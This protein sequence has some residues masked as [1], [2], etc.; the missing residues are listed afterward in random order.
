MSLRDSSLKDLTKAINSFIVDPKLPLPES[1][2]STID[3][4]L[5]KHD[6]SDDS[7]SDR[8]QNEL[9]TIFDKHVPDHPN[10]TGPWMGILRRLQPALQSPEKVLFWFDACLQLLDDG[11]P[12]E[13]LVVDEM[14][15]AM[16]NTVQIANL[17]Q[18][19]DDSEGNPIIDRLFSVWLNK[20]YP[21]VAN[22]KTSA[23]NNELLLRDT[24]MKFGKS[25]LKVW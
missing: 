22:G 20:F 2:V 25:R 13:K 9:R 7:S 15:Q 1:L 12:R 21:A 10:A 8:L 16:M 11:T 23:E 6:N 3:G 4:Y 18:D 14:V 19:P 17:V 5:E 24:L